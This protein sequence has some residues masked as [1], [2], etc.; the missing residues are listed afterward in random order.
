MELKYSCN[1]AAIT[2]AA[3]GR[4][5]R[6]S[7]G[8]GQS[9]ESWCG[10]HTNRKVTVTRF[11]AVAPGSQAFVL[12]TLCRMDPRPSARILIT[13]LILNVLH[14]HLAALQSG[15]QETGTAGSEGSEGRRDDAV[16]VVM[17]N[18]ER[19]KN[20]IRCELPDRSLG[21]TDQLGGT[22]LSP[23][24]SF[25]PHCIMKLILISCPMSGSQRLM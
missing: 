17:L 18:W 6:R 10:I 21:Q 24:G 4:R 16:T 13:C 20:V 11:A 15:A 19:P 8:A 7:V 5:R 9:A 14:G 12:I 1:N 2:D 3:N 25:R 23:S 22:A